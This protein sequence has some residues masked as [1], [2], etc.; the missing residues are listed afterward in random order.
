M[1]IYYFSGTGNSLY[2]AKKIKESFIDCNL[3]P[4]ENI[5]RFEKI[6]QKYK[7]VEFIF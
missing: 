7:K 6:N 1:E 5:S 3:I 2:I 4:I